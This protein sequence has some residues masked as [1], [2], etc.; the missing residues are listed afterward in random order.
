MDA[1]GLFI[2]KSLP[3]CV[4]QRFVAYLIKE[5]ALNDLC[6]KALGIL[7][8]YSATKKIVNQNVDK[9]HS[10]LTGL[11]RVYFYYA[12]GRFLSPCIV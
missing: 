2:F 8:F 1:A 10:P 9:I 6:R 12:A 5:N 4:I 7:Y 3:Q 11:R